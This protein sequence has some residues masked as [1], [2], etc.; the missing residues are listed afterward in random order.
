MLKDVECAASRLLNTMEVNVKE[1]YSAL[2]DSWEEPA[3]YT[4]EAAR[5]ARM[6]GRG[7][8]TLHQYTR[9][10]TFLAFEHKLEPCVGRDQEISRLI[11][12]LSRKTKNKPLSH[13]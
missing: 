12:T 9:D 1:L 8:P 13:R 4:E 11:Q 3:R 5:S 2:L 7:T 10:L 6:Q